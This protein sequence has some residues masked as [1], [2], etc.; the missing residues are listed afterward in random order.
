M[1][2][3]AE[4]FLDVRGPKWAEADVCVEEKPVWEKETVKGF[5]SENISLSAYV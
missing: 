1:W 4:S 2:V 5:K 3:I